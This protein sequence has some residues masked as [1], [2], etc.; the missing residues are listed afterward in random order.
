MTTTIQH[1]LTEALERHKINVKDQQANTLL[2]VQGT[3]VRAQE[4]QV[5]LKPLHDALA[6]VDS[7]R[8]ADKLDAY[9]EGLKAGLV[10]PLRPEVMA[11]WTYEQLAG[12]MF[13]A[14]HD[15]LWALGVEAVTGHQPWQLPLDETTALTVMLELERG[16]RALTQDLVERWQV[17]QDRIYSAARSML[18]HRTR[19]LRPKANWSGHQGVFSISNKDGFDAARATVLCDVLFTELDEFK[20]LFALPTPDL[21]LFV[22]DRSPEHQ[23]RL[24]AAARQAFTES[25]SPLSDALY[26][27]SRNRLTPFSS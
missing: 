23:Q 20:V 1:Q 10:A 27:I 14:A 8:H 22:E 9:A 6:G 13:L 3:G 4:V 5:A 12:K 25:A 24:Q 21:L 26:H 11:Q 18:F 17:T 2:L 16:Q 15:K 19:D 7:A